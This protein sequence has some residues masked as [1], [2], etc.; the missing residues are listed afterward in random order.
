MT[1]FKKALLLNIIALMLITGA[2][3]GTYFYALRC[4]S[5]QVDGTTHT[6]VANIHNTLTFTDITAAPRLV[7]KSDV[8]NITTGATTSWVV[9]STLILGASVLDPNEVV[10]IV[11]YVAFN[12]TNG[13]KEV[14]L[15]IGNTIAGTMVVAS[16]N[17]GK[18]RVHFALLE[19]TDMSIQYSIADAI[20]ATGTVT[21]F[22]GDLALTNED[23][24]EAKTIS[25]RERTQ[26]S[27][28][29]EVTIFV[30]LWEYWPKQ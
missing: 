9:G 12:G 26:D 18:S 25:I 15:F 2:S 17:T 11:C 10:E 23:M 7:L 21:G 29:D 14:G 28:A 16:D 19:Y 20:V 1:R 4:K 27:V 24:T 13:T 22:V 3:W 5:L 30:C 8:P 6:D